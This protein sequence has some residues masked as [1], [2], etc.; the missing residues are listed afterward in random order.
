LLP[1]EKLPTLYYFSTPLGVA[2]AAHV[3]QQVVRDAARLRRV[4]GGLRGDDAL[5]CEPCSSGLKR[6]KRSA[7]QS[8]SSLYVALA[9][10]DF[11]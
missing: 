11:Q 8:F 6:A 10:T 3:W 4:E 1:S 9:F 7:P 2:L 5:A